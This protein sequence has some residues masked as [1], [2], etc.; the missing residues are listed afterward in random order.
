MSIQFSPRHFRR[1]GSE[2]HTW[3]F[4]LP[5]AWQDYKSVSLILTFGHFLHLFPIINHK[6]SDY[7]CTL[8]FFL[9][10][11]LY[12]TNLFLN[13]LLH[14]FYILLYY[15]ILPLLFLSNFYLMHCIGKS[16]REGT[17]YT[18]IIVHWYPKHLEHFVA[19]RIS[20][21]IKSHRLITL[22]S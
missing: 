2:I 15:T 3:Q 13:I 21:E 18:S 1:H 16:L 8:V 7:P 9:F 20:S 5:Y 19:H 14:Y 10:L 11:I 12:Y 22:L 6:N 4:F 17:V